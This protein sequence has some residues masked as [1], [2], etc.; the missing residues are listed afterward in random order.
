MHS[1][2]SFRG[3]WDHSEDELQ[4]GVGCDL[5]PTAE[6]F[7][8]EQELSP[9]TTLQSPTTQVSAAD[10]TAVTLQGLNCAVALSS[11]ELPVSDREYE[12]EPTADLTVRN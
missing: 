5:E 3:A 9:E 1:S 10:E 11:P 4:S 7:P 2:V 8:V 12:V 6:M